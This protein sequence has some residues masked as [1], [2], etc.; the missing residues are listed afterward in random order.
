[1]KTCVSIHLRYIHIH[2]SK[3]KIFSIMYTRVELR[4]RPRRIVLTPWYTQRADKS[5]KVESPSG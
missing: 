2:Y 3:N 5:T 1:M 4:K